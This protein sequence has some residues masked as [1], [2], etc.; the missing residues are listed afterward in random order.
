M[1]HRFRWMAGLAVLL[2]AIAVGTVAYNAGMSHG[3][4]ISAPAVGA[5]P[6]AAPGGPAAAYYYYARRP[7][8][9][10]FFPLGILLFWFLFA[11]LF[12]WGG[13]YRRHGYYPGPYDAPPS[14]DEWHRRAHERMNNPPRE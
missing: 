11:R 4:A 7:W 14:F 12:F 6:G 13:W 9:F 2:V 8:G 1:D 3:L 10:G 5:A